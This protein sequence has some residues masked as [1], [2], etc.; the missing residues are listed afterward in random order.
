MENGDQLAQ[1][2]IRKASHHLASYSVILPTVAVQRL[3]I[4]KGTPLVVTLRDDHL[5]V[6]RLVL[7]GQPGPDQPGHWQSN[8]RAEARKKRPAGKS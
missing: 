8:L 7:P 5:E 6:R 3:G 4:S 1:Q 2:W